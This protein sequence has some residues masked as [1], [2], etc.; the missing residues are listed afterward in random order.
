MQTVI[1]RIPIEFEVFLSLFGIIECSLDIAVFDYLVCRH[2][3][4]FFFDSMECFPD[5]QGF[6]YKFFRLGFSRK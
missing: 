1:K 3:Q 2:W 5:N 4:F 6:R